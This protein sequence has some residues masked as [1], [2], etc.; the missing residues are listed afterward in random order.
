MCDLVAGVDAMAYFGVEARSWAH[1]H[2]VGIGIE[3]IE[4]STGSDLSKMAVNYG[5]DDGNRGMNG[6]EGIGDGQWMIYNKDFSPRRRRRPGR[7]C[8]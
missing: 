7:S 3:N 1:D 6:R 2:Y 4:D 8:S 5:T